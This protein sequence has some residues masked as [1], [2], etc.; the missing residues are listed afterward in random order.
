MLTGA[1]MLLLALVML[2]APRRWRLA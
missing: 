1:L 2:Y